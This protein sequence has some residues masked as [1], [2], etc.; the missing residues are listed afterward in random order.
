VLELTL[1]LWYFTQDFKFKGKRKGKR[2]R[3]A[4]NQQAV[5]SKIQDQKPLMVLAM[6]DCCRET[7]IDA[8]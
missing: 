5:L 1:P 4:V 8:R 3:Y 7:V 2:F 6:L